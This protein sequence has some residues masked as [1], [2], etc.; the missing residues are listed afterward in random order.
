[1]RL[2]L[3]VLTGAALLAGVPAANA[4]KSPKKEKESKT[5]VRPE[6]D[7][8]ITKDGRTECVFRRF[9]FDSALQ[10]RP[11]IGVQTN[12]TGTSRDSLGLF[13]ARVTPDG[14]AEKA[15]IVEGDR[16]VSI[17]GVDLRVSSADAGDDF[18]SQL[19]I[20]RLTREVG[21][22][23]PGQVASVR[24]WSGG[25]IRDVQVTV[26]R[27]SDLREAGAFG[28]VFPPMEGMFVPG[29]ENLRTQLREM[30][31]RRMQIVPRNPGGFRD[32]ILMEEL[33][34]LRDGARFRMLAPS[35]V[36]VFKDGEWISKD[37]EWVSKDGEWR[38]L[39]KTEKALKEK[40]KSEKKKN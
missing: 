7:G 28:A 29:F 20:R 37:G 19:P 25:R 4:Q 11:A 21:K 23:N 12:S 6:G 5:A 38:R 18:A 34:P 40:E 26:G 22:L 8:C 24:V 33:A 1:M 30:P 31:L 27:A 13:V 16:L 14:P 10:K 9:D 32:R 15:G 39:E 36:R 17:N 2:M 3:S 35:R